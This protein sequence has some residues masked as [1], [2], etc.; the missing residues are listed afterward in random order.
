[1]AVGSVTLRLA[2][3]LYEKSVGRSLF[4]GKLDMCHMWYAV[5]TEPGATAEMSN[6]SRPASVRGVRWAK[7]DVTEQVA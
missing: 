6:L 5:C 1:M 4:H 7:M 2:N 3:V